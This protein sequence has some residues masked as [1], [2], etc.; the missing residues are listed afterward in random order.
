MIHFV[1]PATGQIYFA[2]DR[3]NQV[4]ADRQSLRGIPY[5]THLSKPLNV[6]GRRPSRSLQ[7]GDSIL[8]TGTSR[9]GG[10]QMNRSDEREHARGSGGHG[11]VRKGHV[12]NRPVLD[13]RKRRPGS[14]RPAR[15][16]PRRER[17]AAISSGRTG[18]YSEPCICLLRVYYKLKLKLPVVP[19]PVQNLVWYII[20]YMNQVLS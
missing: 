15:S 6:P 9:W 19:L 1:G 18:D 8:S 14:R 7:V 17:E 11:R 12:D 4:L 13:F 10:A 3:R 16:A 20:E 5:C 2:T